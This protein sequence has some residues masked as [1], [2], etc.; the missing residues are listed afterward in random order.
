M[1][2]KPFWKGRWFW[3]GLL[4]I[5][6]AVGLIWYQENYAVFESNSGLLAN[7]QLAAGP[8][9]V[10]NGGHSCSGL[11]FNR[12]RHTL[13]AILG[14]PP[15]LIEL[16][17]AGRELRRIEMTGFTD[18][19]GVEY[20]GSGEI[21]VIEERS[22]QVDLVAINQQTKAI[23]KAEARAFTVL[24]LPSHNK[25]LE[26]VAYAPDEHRLYLAKERSPR[27]LLT[28]PLPTLTTKS[29]QINEPFDMEKLPWWGLRSLSDLY[30]DPGTHHLLV[31]S[32]RSNAVVELTETGQEV[33]RFSLKG[34]SAGISKVIHKAEGLA[35]SD[36]GTM[37]ICSE[38]N[39]LYLF[40]PQQ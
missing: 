7:Y 22:G 34:G 2:A 1:T 15:Q 19:E 37:Y 14:A 18:T 29:A 13:Y 31:L 38:L 5:T 8:I 21:A 27:K 28:M 35:L 6:L 20:L 32:R 11:S 36:D 26:G 9:P 16:D 23:T 33:G 3:F 30:F 12:D 10:G 40:Q 24:P 39:Q 25:G 17:L 4:A